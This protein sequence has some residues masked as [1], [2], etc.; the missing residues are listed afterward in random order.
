MDQGPI[1][2]AVLVERLRTFNG[3]PFDIKSHIH[4]MMAGASRLEILKSKDQFAFETVAIELCHEIIHRNQ[5]LLT[6]EPDVAIVV[7]LT[8][9]DS[10]GESTGDFESGWFL[11]GV[12]WQ[13]SL[14]VHLA[15]VPWHRLHSW[16]ENGTRLMISEVENIPPSVWSPSLKTRS[17][18]QYYLADREVNNKESGSLAVLLNRTGFVTETSVANLLIIDKNR[19][20]ATPNKKDVLWGIS[21][22][23][24]LKFAKELGLDVELRDISPADLDEARE[25]ILTGT[26]GCVWHA[27]RWNGNLVGDGTCQ[28]F[29]SLLKARWIQEV[30]YDF[31]QQAFSQSQSS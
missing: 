29:T 4:R 30:G 22:E 31:E 15:P 12:R 14:V 18:L 7:L 28:K 13:C 19:R 3:C 9:G 27:S 1:H 6:Q 16:Y 10:L 17:R 11:N 20:L 5:G 26:M 23:W 2:G 8:P 21:L 25:I 24:T